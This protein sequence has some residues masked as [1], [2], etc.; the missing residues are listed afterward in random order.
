LLLCLCTMTAFAQDVVRVG[1]LKLVHYN[2]IWYLDKVGAK[3]NIKFEIREFKKGLDAMEAMKAGEID[4]ASSGMDGAISARAAGIPVYVVAGFSKGGIMMLCRPDLNLKTILDLKGKKVGVVRGGAQEL[5]LLMELNKN[6]LTYSDKEGKD[7]QIVY[8]ASY[9]AVNEAMS[10]KSIDAMCQS[11][12]QSA[13]AI[14][15]GFAKEMMRPYDTELGMPVKALTMTEK[16]YNEKH[17][18]AERAI[19]AFTEATK[20]F[21]DNPDVAQKYFTETV[22]KGS[23]TPEEYKA[24]IGNSPYSYDVTTDHV[25]QTIDAMVRCGVGKMDKPPVA[26]D[27]V[28]TDLLT[29]A[30]KSMN[31]K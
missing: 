1:A 27:F 8:L 22:Y 17:D 9:A 10:T 21:I 20:Y 5:A 24:A 30:K 2:A 14:L 7:V 18:V 29:A 23:V 25:Q 13:I 6:K 11:E 12:P 4:I 16:L 26:K 3:Y 19:K 31:I 28:K 15:K